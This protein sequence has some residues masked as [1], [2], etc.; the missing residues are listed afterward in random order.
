MKFS[1]N[2]RFDYIKTVDVVDKDKFLI[3]NKNLDYLNKF[4]SLYILDADAYLY[5]IE[6][7]EKLL[8]FQEIMNGNF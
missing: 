4:E 2:R 8:L 5:A 3:I 7:A 1:N 6:T